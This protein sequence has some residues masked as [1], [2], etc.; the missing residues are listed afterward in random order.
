MKKIYCLILM[1]WPM[2]S[3]GQGIEFHHGSLSE[4][5]EIA[6]KEGKLVFV[7][8]YTDWC[9]PCKSM[10]KNIFPQ[11]E[12][13]AYFNEHFINLK[14]DAEK[15]GLSA[16]RL[17]G[18]KSYPTYL[19]LDSDGDVVFKETGSRS[20]ESF[21]EVANKAVK[22]VTSEYSLENLTLLFPEKQDD[23]EFL[24]IYIKKMIE[25]GQDPSEGIELWLG[26]QTEIKEHYVEMMEF[27]L[28]HGRYLQLGG[29]ADRI[30]T[31]NF[32]EYMDIATEREEL[33]L[34]KLRRQLAGNTRSMALKEKDTE[35]Y[36]VFLAEYLTLPRFRDYDSKLK[37]YQMEYALLADDK[38][39]YVQLVTS[40]M[41]SVMSYESIKEIK[42]RD[43]KL[44]V[45][46]QQS[47][48]ENPTY[49]GSRM[50]QK[51]KAGISAETRIGVIIYFGH[52]YLR[53][54]DNK[55]DYK[56]IA[57]WISYGRKLSPDHYL[58][59]NL[60]ADLLFKQGKKE[61]AIAMKGQAIASWPENDKKL[62]GIRSQLE[63]MNEELAASSK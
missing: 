8:F 41:D 49:A 39:G 9:I 1:I 22:S 15:E 24:K 35:K 58:L 57:S 29:N 30:L 21:L 27:L 46:Y 43:Q 36:E 48:D 38:A 55:K 12:V 10:A 14:L 60:Q 4:G 26:V 6:E 56:E 42:E 28:D 63:K 3:W 11:E 47:Y 16:A 17:Y 31:E 7:D 33:S 53:I 5:L 25:Y 59:D 32:D 40:Y 62:R 34:E 50:L 45:D 19:F 23:E 13:G 54:A 18:V 51:Y 61:E 44:Y 2:L 37:S 20:K 52:Q